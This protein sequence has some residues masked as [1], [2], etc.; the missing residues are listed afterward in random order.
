MAFMQLD[1]FTPT[2]PESDPV[3]TVIDD[4]SAFNML[5][6]RRRL[7]EDI[8]PT[9]SEDSVIL[10]S[11]RSEGFEDPY[12]SVRGATNMGR[13][14]QDKIQ[15]WQTVERAVDDIMQKPKEDRQF[16]FREKEGYTENVRKLQQETAS[17][18]IQILT[19][20]LES[21]E[22]MSEVQ[23]SYLHE[24]YSEGWDQLVEDMV[25]GMGDY[26][27]AVLLVMNVGFFPQTIR[28]VQALVEKLQ[29]AKS[30]PSS[31]GK[32]DSTGILILVGVIAVAYFVFN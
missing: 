24:K 25:K 22:D 3:A 15:F 29:P 19:Q 12:G 2:I 31:S 14:I 18:M 30:K 7:P 1:T 9:G 17:N 5:G 4:T 8:P 21:S 27:D 26:E 13:I 20:G 23:R 32:A 10:G 28:N 11:N 6:H 16:S